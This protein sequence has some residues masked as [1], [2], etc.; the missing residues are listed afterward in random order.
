MLY[1]NI[2]ENTV[3]LRFRFN[4]HI[5]SNEVSYPLGEELFN[6]LSCDITEVYA[7]YTQIA[8]A[9]MDYRYGAKDE[10]VYHKKLTALCDELDRHSI[11]LHAYT[12]DFIENMEL[13]RKGIPFALE[14]YAVG[15]ALE[16]PDYLYKIPILKKDTAVKPP[17]SLDF[18][19]GY[20]FDM[21]GIDIFSLPTGLVRKLEKERARNAP[22]RPLSKA[23]CHKQIGLAVLLIAED[24]D[25][26]RALFLGDIA[27]ITGNDSTP[28]GL[29]L[30]QKLYML[31]VRRESNWKNPIYNNAELWKTSFLPYP[32]IPGELLAQ[33]SFVQIDADKVLAYIRQNNVEIKQVH[34]LPKL[35]NLI[36]FELLTLL[37]CGAVIKKCKFCGNYF[38]P[39]GRPDAVFCER[40]AK[41]EVKPCRQIGAL[42]LHK[43]AKADNPIHEAHQKAYRRMNA[44]ARAK[45]I[46]QS[47]FF[48]WSEE[49]RGKRD[50]CLRGELE[51]A[52][53]QV[54]LDADKGK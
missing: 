37:D 26:K 34:E 2:T 39:Q 49:A 10:T 12:L 5:G 44:K 9:F 3:N 17:F 24:L 31:D 27:A 35:Q 36:I 43:A 20:E 48:A 40:I 42:K 32:Q 21:T 4:T 13:V 33:D 16:L 28:D 14:S 25:R 52:E 22:P 1:A 38:V 15:K 51:L 8:G 11:Y 7:L 46:A 18:L 47:E 23:A 29:T 19:D 41:G 30:T 50:A 53:F 6:F 45:R 54:W